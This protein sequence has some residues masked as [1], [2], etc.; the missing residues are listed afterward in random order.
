MVNMAHRDTCVYPRVLVVSAAALNR[1]TATGIAFCSLFEGWP[2]DRL[3]QLHADPVPPDARICGQHLQLTLVDVPLDRAFRKLLQGWLRQVKRADSGKV[4]VPPAS[5]DPRICSGPEK[6]GVWLKHTASAWADLARF[7]LSIEARNWMR[8]YDPDLILSNLGSI[9]QI[10]LALEAARVVKKPIVPFFNDDWP[11]THYRWTLG[12]FVPRQVLLRRLRQIIRTAP[13]GIGGSDYMAEEYQL[14]YGLTFEAFMNCVEVPDLPS[15]SPSKGAGARIRFI[16]TGGLQLE[17][18]NS[19]ADIG[20]AISNL[21][22][23]A[24]LVIYAPESDLSLYAAE[25]RGFPGLRIGGSLSADQVIPTLRSADVLVHVESFG[26]AARDYTRL[27]LSTKI[28]QY[29]ASGRPILAY[30]PGETSSC[31]YIADSGSGVVVG[32]R[33]ATELAIAIRSLI[34]QPTLRDDLGRRGWERARE[35]HNSG[36]E[37]SRFRDILALAASSKMRGLQPA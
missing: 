16:Y 14:R 11:S 19:L 4:S 26:Q 15:V 25:L 3:A 27:S 17:R 20:S 21:H 31:R 24:E 8:A 32:N 37:R 30:G 22:A 10:N 33:D 23:E 36:V 29:M 1:Q 6:W 9:R 13:I 2:A 18:H 34:E 7:S 35:R 12:D 5:A 28:P